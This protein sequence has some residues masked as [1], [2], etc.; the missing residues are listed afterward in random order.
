MN[1]SDKIAHLRDRRQGLY[2]RDG[3]YN[4][5]EAV[6]TSRKLEKFASINEPESVKYALGAMQ[7]VD[8]EYT[9]NTYAEGNRVRDRLAE[10][11]SAASIPVTFEYQGSVPL[12]VHVRGN[13][14]IDLL[15]LHDGFITVAP[16]VNQQYSYNDYKGK[17]PADELRDLRKE[18]INILERRYYTANV[19]K[20]GSKSISLSGG[21]LKR[22][23]DVVPSHWHD[24][25]AWKQ[26]RDIRHRE[27]RILD[28]QNGICLKNRP[29]MHIKTIA[30]K[31]N[32]TGGALRKVIRLLKNL[33]YDASSEIKLSSYDIASIAWHMTPQ[34]LAVPFGVDLLLVDRARVHL[35]YIID[36]E[37]YRTK[38][39]VPDGSRLIYDTQEKL[40][41]TAELYKEIEQL[42]NDVYKEL[43]PL[44]FVYNRPYSQVLAKAIYL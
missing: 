36:N 13:S 25:L 1:Y 10:G 5:T 26:T 24:T 32:V 2:T 35:K 39:W 33:R 42:A 22:V 3:I 30:D 16:E 29:F 43:D 14:D 21:S 18:S 17:S 28:S 40:K 20:S 34:E 31:C 44:A 27:I 9:Q 41:A 19:D 37:V 7:R 8:D 15:V 6:T 12:D 38:L 11:L 4:F 23:V